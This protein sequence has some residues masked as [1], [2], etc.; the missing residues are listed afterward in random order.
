MT[1]TSSHLIVH[2]SAPG[3]HKATPIQK[4][5]GPSPAEI[6]AAYYDFPSEDQARWWEDTG[7][8]FNRML[9]AGQ[10]DVHRQYQFLSFFIHHLLPALGPYPQRWRSTI[11]R[12]GLPIEFSLNFQKGC[13]RLVRIGFEPVSFLSGTPRDPFNG[14]PIGDLLRQLVK[15]PLRDFDTQLFQ[16]LL[17]DCHLSP[18]EVHQV[19]ELL[20]APDANPLK[21]QGAFGFDFLRD[22]TILV[23]GYVFPNLKAQATGIPIGN[24]VADTVRS[25]DAE[26]NQFLPAFSLVHDYMQESTG[27]NQYTFLSCDCVDMSRQ[28][29]KLYGAHTEVT[30][31]KIAEMFTLGGRLIDEPEIM[32]GLDHLREL[33]NLL[34]IGEGTRAFSGGFDHSQDTAASQVLSPMI[35]NYEIHPG[36]RFPVPKFYLPVHGE[37]DRF[38]AES[39]AR[40]W[41]SLGWSEHARSY[42][43]TVEELY[44]D[45]DISQT[46]RLQSWVSYSYTEK[47]GV[48]MS[49]YFHSQSTYL[50]QAGE[51]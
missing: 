15:L 6:L 40:F 51:A 41:D 26:R 47:K 29:L 1:I 17:G 30:W 11:S 18:G 49:V 13:H 28:R 34:R 9:E 33:W 25:L 21:S 12:S 31:P 39:L 3:H 38:V 48:Y 46:S 10:Y 19:Q 16:R 42:L 5:G 24:L 14:I 4:H 36:G 35:W 44:P 45:Q 2:H 22:G 20:K 23:K 43:K 50:W 7:P 32:A 27:Y 37:N 8:L